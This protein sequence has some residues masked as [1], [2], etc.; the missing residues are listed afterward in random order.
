[1][2]ESLDAIRYR[3]AHVNPHTPEISRQYFSGDAYIAPLS[4]FS[5]TER[6]ERGDDVHFKVTLN[7]H[8]YLETTSNLG[9]RSYTDETTDDNCGIYFQGGLLNGV[10]YLQTT[11]DTRLG[12]LFVERVLARF[13]TDGS[14]ELREQACLNAFRI[15]EDYSVKFTPPYI[16]L[17]PSDVQ[18]CEDCQSKQPLT[19]KASQPA[20]SD[21][22]V[23]YFRIFRAG[24]QGVLEGSKGTITGAAVYRDEMLI[25]TPNELYKI[26]KLYQERTTDDG[27]VSIVGTGDIFAIRPRKILDSELGSGGT[28][29]PSSIIPTE[30]ALFFID[31]V[32]N[33]MWAYSGQ[34]LDVSQ[35]LSFWFKDTLA[36]HLYNSLQDKGVVLGNF[37]ELFKVQTAYDDRHDRIVLMVKN[38]R[39]KLPIEVRDEV[40]PI[41]DAIGY[42]NG[43]FFAPPVRPLDQRRG[44]SLPD[45]TNTRFFEPFVFTLSFSLLI[46]TEGAPVGDWLSYHSYTPDYLFYDRESILSVKNGN[47]WAQEVDSKWCEFF[48]SSTSI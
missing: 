1:M 19:Y 24:D 27:I 16:T 31:A 12:E 48:W 6:N 44:Y 46:Q 2:Y 4:F 29:H 7:S 39:P 32:S 15:N 18:V 14:Y 5:V 21:E 23:D 41:Q 43:V 28:I 26:P 45:V 38:Y 42:A 35:G 3:R 36:P 40:G 13:N 8:I 47:L 10:K 33:K 17:N 34:L 20:F 11:S 30:G 37:T 9:L 25:F 22:L